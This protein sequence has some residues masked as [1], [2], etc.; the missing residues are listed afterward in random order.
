MVPKIKLPVPDAPESAWPFAQLVRQV[1]STVHGWHFSFHT[2][3]ATGRHPVLTLHR[4]SNAWLFSGYVP[5]TTAEINLRTPFGAPLFLGSETRLRDGHATYRLPRA[6][7][8]ECRVFVDGQH[9]GVASC[10]ERHPA[11]IGV[12]RRILVSGLC[13]ATLRFSPPAGIAANQITAW[14]NM[15]WPH[16]TGDTVALREHRTPHGL[17]L[18][19]SQPVTGEI[20]FS[21]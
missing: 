16:I 15:P 13:E 11:Q 6:W 7:R 4:H 20:R 2:T 14:H 8:H 12:T 17:M 10:I 18:E 19:T 21:W 5:D 9:D 3:T 1:I